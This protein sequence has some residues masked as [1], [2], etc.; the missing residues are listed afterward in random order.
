MTS[1]NIKQ[2]RLLDE[3]EHIRA[4]TGMYAGS[5]ALETREEM[6]LD[7]KTGKMIT[8]DIEYVPAFIKIFCEIL[9]NSIDEHKRDPK[10][11]DTIKVD[12]KKD[13]SISVYDNGRG[14]P[15]QLHPDT[16][17]Y[18]AETVFSNMRAGSNFDDDVDQQLIG[19]NGVGSTLTNVLS[20]EFNIESAD[21]E[22]VFKQTFKNGMRE[23][24]EPS[25]MP[26]DKRYTKITFTPDYAF[27]KMAGMDEAHSSKIYRRILDVAACNQQVKFYFN[28]A[29][30]PVNTF[31]DYIKLYSD[32]VLYEAS[33]TWQVGVAPASGFMFTAFVNSV[34]TPQGGT[35]IDYA[36]DQLIEPVRAHIKKKFK[37]DVRPSDIKGKMHLF[38]N[39]N[40]NRPKF[41]SQTKERLIS[42]ASEYKTA[43]APSEKMIKALLKSEIIESIVFWAEAKAKALEEEERRKAGKDIDKTNPRRIL[44][45]EDA[46]WAGKKPELCYLFI[47]EGDSAAKAVISGRDP[48]TMGALALRGKPQN[49][50]SVT[51]DKLLGIDPPKNGKKA[52]VDPKKK[53]QTEFVN[54]MIAMGLQMGVKVTSIKDLRYSKLVVTADADHDGDHITGL[55]V[56]N[57][58]KFW[59]ELFELGVMYRFFTPII[60][61][62]LKGKKIPPLAFETERE[63]QAWVDTPGNADKVK[64]FKYYKGLGTST[65][66]DFKGYL[67][68]IND[69][70]VRITLEDAA[71][72]A[73]LINLVFGKEDGSSDLRKQWLDISED[74]IIIDGQS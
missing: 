10:K 1:K 2:Y 44:K 41:S 33:D 54:I 17:K 60:K 53:D 24:L 7:P 29:K 57:I 51:V 73:A 22:S 13:G 65:P 27:F 56:S 18:I 49:A 42:P 62:W 68:N 26:S 25:V 67:S 61:I 40:I 45:L 74:P 43:W 16:G 70:L 5:T 3:I 48:K 28:G 46:S 50:N 64:A 9:D 37:M 15:V 58:Y 52:E 30:V 63:Y 23:R 6:I 59:P 71:Q 36:V 39:A 35:H 55:S 69:H 4:R 34:E 8:A 47:A 38:I 66:E 20:T 11:L 72:D 12:I 14:I 21:G 19:T 32:N 31:L